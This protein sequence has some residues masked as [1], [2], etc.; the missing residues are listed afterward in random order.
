MRGYK[1]AYDLDLTLL[2]EFE[3]T[4]ERASDLVIAL[5]EKGNSVKAQDL[6]VHFVQH[7]KLSGKN[8]IL[9][10]RLCGY[11]FSFNSL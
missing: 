10:M 8:Q 6:Y 2:G 5:K 11:I 7:F 4:L 1:L 9:F 3:M